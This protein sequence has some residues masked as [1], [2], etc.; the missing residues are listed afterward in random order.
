V[1]TK[2]MRIFV[3][4]ALEV[5]RANRQ[6]SV[7]LDRVVNNS[8]IIAELVKFLDKAKA[9]IKGRELKGAN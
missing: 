5:E 4:D 3:D 7:E 1:K 2:S 6:L 9:N 8:E